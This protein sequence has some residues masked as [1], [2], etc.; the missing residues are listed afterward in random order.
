MTPLQNRKDLDYVTADLESPLADVKMDIHAMPFKDNSFDL[1]L[2]NHVLEHVEDDLKALSEIKRVLEPGGKAIL[3]VPFFPPIPEATIEDPSITDPRERERL[4][5]QDDHVR[6]YGKD[7]RDRIASAG[8]DVQVL[9]IAKEMDPL[10]AARYGLM[11]GEE[12]FL[13]MKPAG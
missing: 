3:Q 5:G 12:L 6:K 8:L 7:Y 11:K 10:L 1:V 4:F 9:R 2:C 13:G